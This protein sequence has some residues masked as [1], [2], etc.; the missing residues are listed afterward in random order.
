MN[1]VSIL[2]QV[3]LDVMDGHFVPN[4]SWGAPV[5]KCLKPVSVWNKKKIRTEKEG[6]G[7]NLKQVLVLQR[8]C[9]AHFFIAFVRV[10]SLN[11]ECFICVY[12]M[13]SQMFL[14]MFAVSASTQR[15]FLMFI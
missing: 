15:P 11:I 13:T 7:K 2:A 8:P 14:F 9:T 6:G 10:Q 4:L 12:S 1:R 5:V 3:H